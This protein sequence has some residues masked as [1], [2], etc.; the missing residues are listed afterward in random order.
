MKKLLLI[1]LFL[2]VI[3]FGQDGPFY[4][5]DN[6]IQ[7]EFYLHI[8][9]NLPQNS[10]IVYVFHG[11][12]GSGSSIMAT[13]G[14]NT[15]SDQ[16]N[17]AVCYPTGLNGEWDVEGLSDVDFIQRLTDS[18]VNEHQFN[19]NKVFAT[20]FSYGAE[21]SYHLV[22]CQN[23]KVFAAIAPVGTSMWDYTTNGWAINCIPTNN[24]S[25]FILNGTNDNEFDY[26]GG[27]YPNVGSYFSVDSTVSYWADF[28]SCSIS[29]NYTLTD[30]NNDNYLTEVTKYNNIITGDKVWLYKVNNGTHSWFDKT[31]G[32]TDDF[33]ASEEIWNFFASVSNVQTGINEQNIKLSRK[34]IKTI[35]VLGQSSKGKQNIPLFYIYD[36]GTVEKEI[37]IE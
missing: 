13:T 1:L 34:L 30:F 15:L 35:N 9:N 6:N 12:F 37:I 11:W 20:G 5:T 21:L 28:N 36:D 7:R 3:G 17:F 33:W 26:N 23:T 16:N 18:I 14:F 29:S 8:P 32:G 22:N 10:P 19:V 4:F 2:P 31:P 27:Y 25:V 24:I